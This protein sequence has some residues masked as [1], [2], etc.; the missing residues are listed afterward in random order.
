MLLP[1][2]GR[3]LPTAP[4][5]NSDTVATAAYHAALP[6]QPPFVSFIPLFCR[7]ARTPHTSS[8]ANSDSARSYARIT[9][10]S[11][12]TRPGRAWHGALVRPAKPGWLRRPWRLDFRR[13]PG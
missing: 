10:S 1:C 8:P 11:V 3:D 6:L 9:Q 12:P 5:R 4:H 7:R 13:K 2:E